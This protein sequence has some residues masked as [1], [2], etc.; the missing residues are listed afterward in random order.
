[1]PISRCSIVET[2][3]RDKNV[4]SWAKP[5]FAGEISKKYCQV[6][7]CGTVMA[8]VPVRMKSAWRIHVGSDSRDQ[9]VADGRQ[10]II[11]VIRMTVDERM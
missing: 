4:F 5:M 7:F 9:F 2:A 8:S 6:P 3:E 1:M 10:S 11:A